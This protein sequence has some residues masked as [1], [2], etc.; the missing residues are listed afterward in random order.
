MVRDQ[1]IALRDGDRLWYE[2][3]L[4]DREINQIENST[5]ARVIRRNTEIGYELQDNVFFAASPTSE[6]FASK[7]R[8]RQNRRR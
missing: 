3:S 8:P 1:F 6:P 5:L 2:N 7:R 4:S